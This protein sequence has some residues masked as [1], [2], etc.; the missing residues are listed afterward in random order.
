MKVGIVTSAYDRKREKGGTLQYTRRLVKKLKKKH[1]DEI[2]LIHPVKSEDSLYEGVEEI[3]IPAGGKLQFLGIPKLQSAIVEK[4]I[5]AMHVLV[6]NS[7]DLF[8][9]LVLD[10]PKIL[11]VHDLYLFLDRNPSLDVEFSKLLLQSVKSLVDRFIV[12]SL[13]TMKD[14]RN[15]LNVPETDIRVIP[16]APDVS[17]K[18]GGNKTRE[19]PY[20]LAHHLHPVGLKAFA[21]LKKGGIPHKLLIFGE[22]Y[23]TEEDAK[24]MGIREDVEILGYVSKEELI[25]LYNGAEMFIR[26]IW[27]EGFGLPP[28]EAMACGCPVIASNVGSLPEILDD[29]ALLVENEVNQWVEAMTRVIEDDG[30]R[31]DLSE[32][33]LSQAEK[34]SWGKTAEKTYQVYREVTEKD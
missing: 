22:S 3:I 18:P 14:L 7:A 32:R 23:G 27:Y 5:D 33:S 25:A 19:N 30:L 9:F 20:I 13:S 8:N 28:L 15:I 10:I 34:Y 16:E 26:P 21:R 12:P 11:T 4:S 31:K 17:F 24:N 6:Q 2:C 29:A 1:G